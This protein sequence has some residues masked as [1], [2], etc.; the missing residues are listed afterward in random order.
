[1]TKIFLH[2]FDFIICWH[3]EEL[4]DISFNSGLFQNSDMFWKPT[5]AV[6]SD[7]A[8]F[9]VSVIGG[10]KGYKCDPDW[11]KLLRKRDIEKETANR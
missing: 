1:M 4:E 7:V 5:L 10:L 8:S 11:V 2:V 3:I 6:Q 9:L